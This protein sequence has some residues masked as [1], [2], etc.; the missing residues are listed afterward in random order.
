MQQLVEEFR[1]I[2][3]REEH[4]HI[5]IEFGDNFQQVPHS[6]ASPPYPESARVPGCES[7]AYLFSEKLPNGTLK[8]RFAVEN[9]QGI[10]AMALAA[11]V[12][13]TLSGQPLEG[14][15]TIDEKVIYEFFGS[16]VSMGKGQGLMGM[17]Q[18]VRATAKANLQTF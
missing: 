3:D 1:T 14:I 17:I 11:I 12:D 6:I 8:F 4:A 7:E 10:S 9:P 13:E 16:D 15:A 18:L 2:S 5:L